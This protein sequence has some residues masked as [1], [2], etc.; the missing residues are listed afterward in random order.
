MYGKYFCNALSY[1][2]SEVLNMSVFIQKINPMTGSN[3]WILQNE[4]YDYHQEVARA[5]FADML[6]DKERNEK[7]EQAL[8]SAIKNMHSKGRKANV[9][10]IGTGTGL[11]SMMAARNGA[12]LVVACEAFNPMSECAKKIISRNGFQDQIKIIPKRSTKLTVGEEGDLKQKCN[13][14]VTEVFDS[15]LI[16]EGALSTF[17]HA[18]KHLLEEDSIVVPD[19]ATIY[20]QVVECPLA[21]NWNKVKNIFNNDGELLVSIPKSI[22]TCPGTAAVHDIQLSQLPTH[23]FNTIIS[24]IPVLRF[25]WS[26][27]TPF[28]FDRFTINT[29]KSEHDGTAQAV[30]MW[31]ELQMDTEGKITLSCAPR[32][33]HPD[34]KNDKNAEIP[35]RDHWMQAVYYLPN[36]VRVKKGQEVHLISCHDEYSLWFN[37]TE[38]LRLSEG[39]YM[40]PVCT[41]GVHSC[42]SR[43]RVGQV[44]DPRR[45][46]KYASLFETHINSDSTVLILTEGFYFGLSSAKLAK[47]VFV[48]ETNQISRRIVEEFIRHNNIKNVEVIS[49]LDV[50]NEVDLSKVN[51]VISEPYFMSS[52]L[53]WDNLLLLYLLKSIRKFI[54]PDAQIFPKKAVLKG[55]AVHFTDL[56]KIRSPL[57]T[58]EGFP[59]EDFDRLIGASSNISDDKVEAQPLWEYPGTALSEEMVIAE[60]DLVNTPESLLE[61][62]GTFYLQTEMGCNG[63]ALWVDWDM[64]GSPKHAVTTGPIAPVVIGQKI[65]WDMYT[66]QG[67]YLFPNKVMKNINYEFKYDFHEGNITFNCL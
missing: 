13:I 15:E 48:T 61:L 59:M 20:A 22:K 21:Q 43:T 23:S 29:V 9:L 5:A 35:W 57:G 56:Y 7:Y 27:K 50:L 25:D 1:I 2:R 60:I 67:V 18:H 4:D 53:P 30:F 17:S 38:N 32:W 42:F 6:H 34:T 24:P 16:G 66:R 65:S 54:L 37:L 44:N 63:I 36:E 58:C 10:D 39:H 45:N 49:N 52:I 55:V 51:V 14:L 46:K 47:K 28:V 19:S 62:K 8:I 26:G 12:D 33:A 40:N 41:C 3:D 64:D 31:W 11:L